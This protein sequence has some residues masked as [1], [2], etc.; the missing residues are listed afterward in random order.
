MAFSLF[1]KNAD[2]ADARLR[3][4]SSSLSLAGSRPAF[5]SPWTCSRLEPAALAILSRF[6][7]ARDIYQS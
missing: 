5:A 3:S 6:G 2:Y 1:G 4:R 7:A